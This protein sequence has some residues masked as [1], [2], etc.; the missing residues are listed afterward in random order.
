MRVRVP[1]PAFFLIF[2]FAHLYAG[3][4]YTFK[5]KG[6][7]VKAQ[8]R[9]STLYVLEK[10][11]KVSLLKIYSLEGKGS[12]ILAKGKIDDFELTT[13]SVLVFSEGQIK[14]L[15]SGR[16]LS[17]VGMKFNG[18][19]FRNG[20]IFLKTQTPGSGKFFLLKGNEIN[21]IFSYRPQILSLKKGKFTYYIVVSI[22][23]FDSDG[24]NYYVCDTT[25]YEIKKLDK[26]GKVILKIKIGGTGTSSPLLYK[27]YKIHGLKT[28]AVEKLIYSEKHLFSFTNIWKGKRRRIDILR[29]SDLKILKTTWKDFQ[30]SYF[31]AS[32]KY[33]IYFDP[34]KKNIYIYKWTNL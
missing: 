15:K 34:F 16:V 24:R 3:E 10:S 1:P 11:G 7:V 26:G 9:D 18:F 30:T 8:T 27:L 28:Y 23:A 25:T 6:R 21:E 33:I 32:G 2:L 13:D 12:K 17:D 14:E 19:L 22:A 4:V 5:L 31:F 29:A 20:K